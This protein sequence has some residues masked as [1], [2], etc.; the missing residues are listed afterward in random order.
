MSYV[1]IKSE[2]AGHEGAEHD[3]FTVGFY[4]PGGYWEAD[5]D[6]TD[7]N[8]AAERVHYLNGGKVAPASEKL[9]LEPL[10]LFWQSG[11][12]KWRFSPG[13]TNRGDIHDNGRPIRIAYLGEEAK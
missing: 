2:R 10:G 3:L 7:E 8:K 5:S 13:S 6:H 1:Y 9:A 11:D 4:A 12:G